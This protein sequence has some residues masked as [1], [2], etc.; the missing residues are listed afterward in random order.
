ML[1]YKQTI[2]KMTTGS[3][4]TAHDLAIKAYPSNHSYGIIVEHLAPI[5]RC[6]DLINPDGN[7]MFR[8][9]SKELLGTDRYHSQVRTLAVE[10]MATNPNYFSAVLAKYQSQS[11]KEHILHIKVDH[12]WGTAVE[13]H[14]MACL[15]QVA[16]KVLAYYTKAPNYR[17]NTYIPQSDMTKFENPL[18]PAMVKG[19]A[20]PGYSRGGHC[21]GDCTPTR[22]R[23][24][25]EVKW[26]RRNCVA[27]QAV[28][29]G[30]RGSLRTV[31]VS[32][33]D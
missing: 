20:P 17:W 27:G 3:S 29:L 28:K 9:V 22:D 21:I 11:L 7:C 26:S 24:Q 14:A 6:I 1:A 19:R 23:G 32:P 16:I 5:K 15:Y 13:L 25:S 31:K 30:I 10:F 33:G 4:A 8:A 12:V 18:H 2:A